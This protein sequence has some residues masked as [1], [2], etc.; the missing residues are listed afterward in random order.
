MHEK[1]IGFTGGRASFKLPTIVLP[2]SHLMPRVSSGGLCWFQLLLLAKYLGATYSF[3]KH[4]FMPQIELT[5]TNLATI[6]IRVWPEAFNQFLTL[7]HSLHH[8]IIAPIL[9]AEFIIVVTANHYFS[10]CSRETIR[11]DFIQAAIM[12]SG[13]GE[14]LAIKPPAWLSANHSNG[15]RKT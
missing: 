13:W 4:G 2:S 12:P 5:Q 3:L 7:P 8:M 1:Y 14:K 6:S 11:L 15:N 9:I 10:I